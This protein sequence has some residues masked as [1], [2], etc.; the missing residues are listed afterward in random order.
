[1]ACFV[2]GGCTLPSNDCAPGASSAALGQKAIFVYDDGSGEDFPVRNDHEFAGFINLVRSN[3][4]VHGEY[5]IMILP[6]GDWSR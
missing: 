3:K 6:E 2:Q 4:N 1:M 5:D